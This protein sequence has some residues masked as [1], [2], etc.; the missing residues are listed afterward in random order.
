MH[1]GEYRHPLYGL[2]P[3][4]DHHSPLSFLGRCRRPKATLAMAFPRR[5]G[6]MTG[7]K[8]NHAGLSCAAAKSFA[9]T[10]RATL[11]RWRARSTPRSQARICT[12][13]R[14]KAH[15]NG[16]SSS[17]NIRRRIQRTRPGT[18]GSAATERPRTSGRSTPKTSL[19]RDA[20]SRTMR[21]LPRDE[22]RPSSPSQSALGWRRRVWA[23]STTHPSRAHPC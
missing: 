13:Y 20:A 22:A 17:S 11:V 15:V 14:S 21:P 2:D 4:V 6:R 19:A 3:K 1:T 8:R 9:V 5:H 7:Y 16:P 12:A 23:T 18:A 10:P